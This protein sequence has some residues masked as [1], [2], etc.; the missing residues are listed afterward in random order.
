MEP[1]YLLKMPFMNTKGATTLGHTFRNFDQTIITIKVGPKDYPESFS[2]HRELLRRCSPYFNTCLEEKSESPYKSS[3][4][5]LELE[6]T[7]PDVFD[8]FMVRDS[9]SDG[10]GDMH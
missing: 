10:M 9:G 6:D 4:T 3:A 5:T 7:N 8:A 2:C 1:D